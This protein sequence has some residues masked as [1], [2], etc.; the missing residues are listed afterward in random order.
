[1]RQIVSP[2]IVGTVAD[3]LAHSGV[4]PASLCLEITESVFMDDADFYGETLQRLRALGVRLSIDDF[5]T[6]YSSLSYLKR[7]P[8]DGVKVDK[9]FIDGLGNDPHD[10][11]LV[12]AIVAVA[13]AL[14]LIVTA[15]GV[16][17]PEQLS[18]LRELQCHRGQGYYLA[19][20]M[21]AAKI[22]QL[23]RQAHR[24]SVD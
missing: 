18:I 22:D 20:P 13:D 4:D 11:A 14:G 5:G 6:G 24:W 9:A 1:V 19:K 15:E 12:A 17:N 21:P 7:F 8:V 16:E 10:T 2:G 3:A 23:V